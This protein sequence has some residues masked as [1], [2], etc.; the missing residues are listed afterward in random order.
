MEKEKEREIMKRKLTT[1]T[2]SLVIV[3]SQGTLV[4]EILMMV[5][6]MMLVMRMVMRMVVMVVMR[7]V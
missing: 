1:T 5:M 4:M 2:Q 3:P 6:V 7:M